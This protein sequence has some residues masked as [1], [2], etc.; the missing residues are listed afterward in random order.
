M[1]SVSKLLAA[2]LTVSIFF[3][4]GCSDESSRTITVMTHDSFSISREVLEEYERTN[5]IKLKIIKSGDAGSALN[6]AILSKSNPLA[7]VFYGVDSTFLSRALDADIFEPYDSPG[8][9]DVLEGLS[10]DSKNRLLPVD[11]GDVCLNYDVEL[12]SKKGIKPPFSLEDLTKPE[13]AGMVVVENPATSSPGLAFLLATIAEYGEGG[14]IDYWKRLMANDTLVVQNWKVAYWGKFS[15]SSNG[16]SGGDRPIVVS[17]ASSPPAEIYYA[18]KP[19]EKQKTAAI[20]SPGTC[21]RQVEFAGILRGTKKRKLAEQV[22]DFFLSIQFQE[23]IP[24]QM[25]VYPSNRMAALPEVFLLYTKPS[26]SPISL[27]PARIAERRD[28]WIEEWTA[29]ILRQ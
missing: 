28:R 11:Y 26:L 19:P 27:E 29:A 10:L 20:I 23:D 1:K 13:Y 16:N 25:F 6:Q 9:A 21:Y 8:L 17:Y 7:D 2:V 18:E 14:Y 15:G 5:N 3:L 4:M 22:I 24:L 12:F